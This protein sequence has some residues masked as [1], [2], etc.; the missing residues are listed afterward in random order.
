MN[1]VYAT[2]DLLLVR[3]RSSYAP[4]DVA[5]F[6]VD[7]GGGRN[8]VIHR[9]IGHLE[10]GELVLQGDNR[11][12][13][14]PWHPQPAEVIGSPAL[15]VPGVGLLA[16]RLAASPVL[17]GMVCASI[18]GLSVGLAPMRTRDEVAVGT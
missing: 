15:R 13:P 4:G 1:P 18:A 5:A 16:G 10:T 8:V 12:Q 14:D 3:P 6:P 2:G 7:M 11:D 17:L 9:V